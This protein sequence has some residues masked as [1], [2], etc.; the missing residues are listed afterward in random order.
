MELV[1]SLRPI[2]PFPFPTLRTSEDLL[3]AE[4]FKIGLLTH[5]CSLLDRTKANTQRSME[6]YKKFHDRTAK[7]P[8]NV[9]VGDQV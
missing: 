7:P 5:L 4:Q 1:T 3:S 9:R 8:Q 2:G 6:S